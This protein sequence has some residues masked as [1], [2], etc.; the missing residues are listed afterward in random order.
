MS[1]VLAF[2]NQKGGVGKTTSAVSLAAALAARGERVLLVDLD[3]Q[4]NATGALGIARSDVPVS[5]YEALVGTAPLPDVLRRDYRP[6]LDVVPGSLRLAGAEVELVAMMSRE[7]RL[8]RIL[9][10][11][12]NDYRFVLIDSPP[13]LGLLTVNALSAANGV[14]V[15]VQCEYLA[16]EGLSQLVQTV[17][18]VR[19][20]LNPTLQIFGMLMTMWDSRTNLA[21]QV[22]DEVR[23]HFP[24]ETFETVIP[25]NVRLSEAPSYGKPI[26][27][28]DPAS[29]GAVAYDHLADEVL[30][31]ATALGR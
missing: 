18:M 1:L 10:P 16:L 21:Q 26:R 28:Y 30:T 23:A 7:L 24:R 8:Q 31:R 22:V 9:A 5:V 2:A 17:Q 4:A 29:R 12:V 13:S 19:D 14:V 15:P 27:E 20:H 11:V 6:S 3:P 25:R